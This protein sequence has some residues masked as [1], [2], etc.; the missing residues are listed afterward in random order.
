MNPSSIIKKYSLAITLS[1][2]VVLQLI[3]AFQGFDVCDDG[4]VLTFYQQ[5]FANPE[6]VEYNFLYWFAG[7]VGG[8]W[9]LLY[10]D[11]GILWFRILAILV[12][13]ATFYLSYRLLKPFVPKRFLLGALVMVLFVNDFGYLTYYHNQLTALMSVLI[14]YLLYK[15]VINSRNQL[16]IWAGFLL[17]INVFTRIPNVVLFSLVLVIPFAFYLKKQSVYKSVKPILF[18]GLGSVI[19]FLLVYV[20]LS[21][22][23]QVDIMK[24]A[25]LTIVDL[26]QTENS[27]HSFKSVF[28]APFYNYLNVAKETIKLSLILVLYY[29]IKHV[30][31]NKQIYNYLIF[32]VTVV[33]LCYWFNT[34]N[35]YPIYSLCLIG[36]GLVLFGYQ[37]SN[38]LKI[39]GFLSFLTLITIT[40]GTGGGIKNS[41]YMAIWISL[42]LFF[43]GVKNLDLVF[44]KRNSDPLSIKLTKPT[45]QMFLYATVL[46]FLMLK[47]YHISQQS[48]FDS[49]SRLHKTF[50][51][52]SPL[53]KGI[54]TT[55]RRAN[56]INDLLMNLDK[57][58]AKDD[59]LMIYDKIPM[60][61][62]LTVTK[63]YMYNPWVWIYDYNSFEKKLNKAEKEISKLPI[64][65]QQKFDT[66]YEFSEPIDDYMS[67]EK[68][69][70]NAHSNER[71]AIMNAF[72]ERN[73]YTIVWSNAYFNIF[74]A[75]ETLK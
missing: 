70:T 66:F 33:V 64:V 55:E 48:Y 17:S 63:P 24:N 2:I 30:L 47:S 11:G 23:G 13:T 7:F 26:G 43:Y 54:Y 19:G 8:I 9:Y 59:Y 22:L 41:G 65:V 58:V 15:A 5:I 1:I 74:Q 68:Q 20:T 42:P 69:N 71:N 12:N 51:I 3:L 73:H 53:A 29:V 34:H 35:I 25:L 56:I 18:V 4:F 61:H 27:S 32:G 75:D 50:A 28:S 10:E 72:L 31:S 6:S 44:K 52:N 37:I 67:T 16:F 36:C 40:L 62:F 14:I 60:L 21:L 57:Y 45:V 39:I 38:A 46:A 49:G